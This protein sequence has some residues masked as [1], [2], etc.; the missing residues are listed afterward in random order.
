M[1][2]PDADARRAAEL[3][4]ALVLRG[5]LGSDVELLWVLMDLIRFVE[6]HT[7]ENE[8]PRP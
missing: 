1:P 8:C 2:V 3:L 4:R 6:E 5:V 7:G